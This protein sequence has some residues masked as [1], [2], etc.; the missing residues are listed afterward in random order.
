LFGDNGSIPGKLDDWKTP[1]LPGRILQKLLTSYRIHGRF[2]HGC[3]RKAGQ[4]GA[5]GDTV[6]LTENDSNGSKISV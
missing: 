2:G 5:G 4:K 6:I 3:V 1:T